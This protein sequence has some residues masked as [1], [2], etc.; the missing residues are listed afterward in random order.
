MRIGFVY[1]IKMRRHKD[2]VITNTSNC[3]L[4][5]EKVSHLHNAARLSFSDHEVE[6]V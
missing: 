3:N 1:W 4:E 6:V 5:S 2:Q